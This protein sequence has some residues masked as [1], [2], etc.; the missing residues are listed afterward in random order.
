LL[1]GGA[2]GRGYL[3]KERVHD[4]EELAS[5]TDIVAPG[6]T[7]IDAMAPAAPMAGGRVDRVH[8]DRGADGGGS[9]SA[10]LTAR[11]SHAARARGAGRD[12]PGQE[13]CRDRRIARPA[14]A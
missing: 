9:A 14:Q 1:E 7:M 10:G 3:L 2:E 4:R 8:C 13:Q 6:G 11:R 5:A 12:G